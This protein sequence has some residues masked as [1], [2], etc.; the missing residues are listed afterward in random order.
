MK[1]SLKVECPAE[2]LFYEKI[3]EVALKHNSEVVSNA[4]ETTLGK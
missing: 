3:K 2:I 1:I 4:L